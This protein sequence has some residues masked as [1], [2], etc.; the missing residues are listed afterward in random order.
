[1]RLRL[2]REGP[3]AYAQLVDQIGEG[4]ASGRLA[5]GEK[6]PTERELAAE[7]GVSR[8]TVRQALKALTDRGFLVRATGRSGGTFVARPKLV[9]DLA[10]FAGLS[11]Q[12]RRQGIQAGARVLSARRRQATVAVAAALELE[13]RERVIEIVRVRLADD[14]PFALERSSFPS[15]RFPDLL[16]HEL[17]GSLYEL[18]AEQYDAAPVRAVE[19]LEPVLA[20]VFEADALGVEAGAPLMLVERTAYASGDEPVEFAQDVFRGDRTRIVA[21]ASELTAT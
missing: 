3:P 8:M 10:T 2:D 17:A 4:I 16:A 12:L 14:E 11:E 19:R 7:L 5:P 20:G 9:R 1:V 15:S 21:W 6:L 13:P 18:L